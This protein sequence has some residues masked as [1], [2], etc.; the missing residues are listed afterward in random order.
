MRKINEELR[1][2][3]ARCQKYREIHAEYE[4]TVSKHQERERELYDQ[5]IKLRDRLQ[6]LTGKTDISLDPAKVRAKLKEKDEAIEKLD[7]EIKVLKHVAS[8]AEKRIKEKEKE[9]RSAVAN[10]QM[11]VE[12]LEGQLK[13]RD[14]DLRESQLLIRKQQALI[15]RMKAQIVTFQKRE[16]ERSKLDAILDPDNDDDAASGGTDTF[17]TQLS[18]DAPKAKVKAFVPADQRP[19]IGAASDGRSSSMRKPETPADMAASFTSSSQATY[20][21]YLNPEALKALDDARSWRSSKESAQGDANAAAATVQSPATKLRSSLDKAQV[22]PVTA[23]ASPGGERTAEVVEDGD[24]DGGYGDYDEDFESASQM[25]VSV[26]GDPTPRSPKQQPA[27]R[28]SVIADGS[29]P[30][31]TAASSSKAPDDEDIDFLLA[32]ITDIAPGGGGKGGGDLDDVTPLS[33]AKP[34]PRGAGAAGK[35]AKGAVAGRRAAGPART[36][37]VKSI[38]STGSS[39]RGSKF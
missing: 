12:S 23:R 38:K 15:K 27:P 33:S 29:P 32:G 4:E 20:H 9:G 34:T 35:G 31:S 39:R 8:K 36:A 24:D 30:P 6:A 11:Q 16:D 26:A 28:A 5:T 17:L 25:S 21:N 3:K 22:S 14:D 1:I 37:S 13:K 10:V 18:D 2:A 19:A 7:K